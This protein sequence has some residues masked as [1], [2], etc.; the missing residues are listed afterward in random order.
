M[1]KIG[2]E[3]YYT[4]NNIPLWLY[5]QIANTGN[6]KL[7][8]KG[9]IKSTLNCLAAWE[10]ITMLMSKQDSGV[11][12]DTLERSTT[13]IQ[14]QADYLYIKACLSK[15]LILIPFIDKETI[16]KLSDL[17]Y[18]ID[19]TNKTTYIKS[20]ESVD[21]KSNNILNKIRSLESRLTTVFNESKKV[22]EIS[23]GEMISSVNVTLGNNYVDQF[24]PL[25]LYNTYKIMAKNKID[26]LNR[27]ANG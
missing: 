21:R 1:S 26:A 23:L 15:L 18:E 10:K 13:Y 27:K 11:Y 17:G 7:V 12:S 9:K 24:T 6:Y 14:L 22:K 4:Y 3:K 8:S 25:E 5:V 20:I 16:S 19:I 2:L